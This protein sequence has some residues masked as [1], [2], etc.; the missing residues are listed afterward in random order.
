MRTRTWRWILTPKR[1]RRLP[2]HGA[3]ATSSASPQ[4]AANGPRLKQK[5]T[6]QSAES[7]FTATGELTPEVIAA[8]KPIIAG[9]SLKSSRVIEELT[10]DGSQISDWAK[11]STETHQSPSG[12][13][14]VHFYQN[15]KTGIVN[16]TFDYKVEFNGGPR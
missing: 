12:D 11:F 16:Y 2:A 7:A 4:N 13:F 8:S 3:P 1:S 10:S 14:Q 9:E 15:L 6:L 5:R